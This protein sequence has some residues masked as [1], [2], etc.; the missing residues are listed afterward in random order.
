VGSLIAWGANYGPDTITNGQWWR[1]LTSMFLHIGIVHLAFN[2]IVL[3]QIGPFVERLVGNVGFLIVYFV[4]GFAGNVTSLVWNPYTVSAGASGAIFG[5]YGLL[6][7]F[8]LMSRRDSIPTDVLA[9]RGGTT[10]S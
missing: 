7:G 10:I 5:L 1:L 2:M 6:L 4:S 8:L 9:A 3:L